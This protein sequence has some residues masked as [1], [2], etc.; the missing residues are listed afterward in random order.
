MADVNGNFSYR[1][2]DSLGTK[3]P[4]PFWFVVDDSNT[5]ADIAADAATFATLLDAV[6]G[7][8]ILEINMALT[9]LTPPGGLKSSP[10]AG[11]RNNQLAN[12][13]MRVAGSSKDFT[14]TVPGLRDT[15]ITGEE[16]NNA[17]AAITALTSALVTPSG[18]VEFSSSDWRDITLWLASYISFRKHRK[19]NISKS[20][21]TV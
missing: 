6:T 7:S 4:A 19:Q 14:S 20:Y 16:I 17:A 1:L 5:V 21:Q 8:E 15:L 11:S 10:V 2:L 9:G 12:F 3:V 18:V 13:P